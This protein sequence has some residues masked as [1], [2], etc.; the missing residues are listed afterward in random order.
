MREMWKRQVRELLKDRFQDEKSRRANYSLRD[1]AAEVG[2]SSGAL[3]EI[4]SGKRK[5][6]PKIAK[7]VVG[8][9]S[10]GDGI[11]DDLL[12][13]INKTH[14]NSRDQLSSDAYELIANWI[15]FA[16]LSILESE[17]E[18]MTTSAIARRL[19]VPEIEATSALDLLQS[20]A[21]VVQNAGGAYSARFKGT[22][23]ESQ[24][25]SDGLENIGVVTSLTFRADDERLAKAQEN[26]KRIRELLYDGAGGNGTNH[27]VYRMNIQLLP[28]D[29]WK[30]RRAT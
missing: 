10:L 8:A 27:P 6:S 24:S 1:L 9:L 4:M 19:D 7:R 15:Y 2:L 16:T 30:K 22:I 17:D 11:K 3:S 20:Y 14:T 25:V 23:K 28:V 26:I 29:E 5:L 12:E 18:P 21:L 13:R